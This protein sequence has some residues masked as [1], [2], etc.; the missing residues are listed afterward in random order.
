MIWAPCRP[1][2]FLS[3]AEDMASCRNPWSPRSSVVAPILAECAQGPFTGHVLF[4][5]PL[6]ALPHM[7]AHLHFCCIREETE[8]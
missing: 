4:G 6:N 1:V 2:L 7:R 5:G 8:A 3:E